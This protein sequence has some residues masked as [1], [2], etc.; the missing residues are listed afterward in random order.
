MNSLARKESRLQDFVALP[1]P[2]RIRIT[3]TSD[4]DEKS[5]GAGI[6]P[7]VKKKQ[8]EFE[9]IQKHVVL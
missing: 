8:V 1:E 9:L 6:K 3:K 7:V 2:K 4:S 5:S